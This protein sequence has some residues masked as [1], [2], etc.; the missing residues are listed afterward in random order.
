[1]AGSLTGANFNPAISLGPMIATANFTDAWLY[2]IAPIVGRTLSRLWCPKQWNCLQR[3]QIELAPRSTAPAEWLAP[4]P[5]CVDEAGGNSVSSYRPGRKSGNDRAAQPRFPDIAVNIHRKKNENTEQLPLQFIRKHNGGAIMTNDSYKPTTTD[6]GIPVASDEH[7]LTV[8]PDGPILLQDH[9]LSSSR[10]R[11]STGNALP[12]PQPGAQGKRRVRAFRGWPRTSANT[13]R[14]HCS[15]RASRRTCWR[16]F[17]PS[18]AARQSRHIAFPWLRV[19]VSIS[20]L[21][22][23]YLL[24][25]N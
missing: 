2:V 16:V 18:L 20:V 9:Y 12:E 23:N 7:S 8:G 25:F 1:M 4:K 10:W 11:T 6:A 21:T 17:E 5:A 22:F 3:M 13:P 19:E 24:V 14:R 15:N